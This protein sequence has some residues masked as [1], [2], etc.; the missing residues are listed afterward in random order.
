VIPSI[1]YELRST[2]TE[3]ICYEVTLPFDVHT[4]TISKALTSLKPVETVDG[5]GSNK[6]NPSSVM[7]SSGCPERYRRGEPVGLR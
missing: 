7:Q 6:N 3:G 5:N 1:P 4:D 2:A